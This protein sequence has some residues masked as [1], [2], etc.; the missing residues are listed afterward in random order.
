MELAA[1]GGQWIAMV[2]IHSWSKGI[3][4]KRQIYHHL[5]TIFPD[6]ALKPDQVLARCERN[7]LIVSFRSYPIG[8][9]LI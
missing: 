3:K 7:H 6:E 4:L 2:L 5:G 1:C 8:R 9:Q